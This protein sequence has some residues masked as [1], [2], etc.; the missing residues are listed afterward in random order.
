MRRPNGSDVQAPATRGRPFIKYNPGR[1]PGSKN[2]ATLFAAAL[3]EGEAEQLLREA[4]ALAKAG[5]VAMLKFLLN[6]ILPRERLVKFDFPQMDFADDAVDALG[7]V[8]QAVSEGRITPSEGA[9]LAL[10]I[11]SFTT[12]VDT[13]DGAKRLDAIE[14][15]LKGGPQI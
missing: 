7:R 10:L 11:N 13:A 15:R 3:L 6:R 12:A 5:N 2:K 14:A 1:P 8:M 9:A 4:V